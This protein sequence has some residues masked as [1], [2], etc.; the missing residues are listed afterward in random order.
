[1]PLARLAA[2]AYVAGD[3]LQDGLR[4]A[5]RHTDAGRTTTLGFFNSDDEDPPRQVGDTYLATIRA[6]CGTDA[7]LSVKLPALA[8]S[9]ELLT[10]VAQQ[11]K[12][13]DLC[14]HFDAM[15]P[16]SAP[17]TLQMIQQMIDAQTC[18]PLGIALPG[19]W[20]RSVHDAR[21]ATRRG[22]MVRVV[23]GQWADPADPQRDP[24]QGYMEVINALAG[25]ARLVAVASHD[26]PLAEQAIRVLQDARTPCELELLHGLPM[27]ASLAM[28]HRMGVKVRVYV[29]FGKGHL[30]YAIRQVIRK[31]RLAWWLLRDLVGL[32]A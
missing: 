22:L 18:G 30:P 31:P 12:H 32:A 17:T 14:L 7:Y 27:R 20:R 29:P 4:V 2:R 1:M 11:A 9:G 6:L 3:A 19:R 15:W 24:R 16:T 5:Q 26:V 10:E 21:W 13:S 23:K 28:A 8:F 25:H